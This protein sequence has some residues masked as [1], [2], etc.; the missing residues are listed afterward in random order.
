M[1]NGSAGQDRAFKD[2][3]I[4]GAG[5][6]GAAVARTARLLAGPRERVTVISDR[7][8]VV[9]RVRLH[10]VVTGRPVPHRPVDRLASRRVRVIVDPAVAIRPEA[11]EV[12]LA[13]GRCLSYDALM[14]AIGSVGSAPPSSNDGGVTWHSAA[15]TDD[16]IRLQSA[17]RSGV[18]SGP[19]TV[20]GA[21]LTGLEVATQIAGEGGVGRV[22]LI[23]AD[24]LAPW[25]TPAAREHLRDVLPRLGVDLVHAAV[26]TARPG[27]VVTDGGDLPAG[28][29]VWTG[30]FAPPPLLERS[31]LR[32]SDG[33]VRVDAHLRSVSHPE[34]FVAG[35]AA[36]RDE[37]TTRAGDGHP[38]RRACQTA[39]PTGRRPPTTRS[40][41][42]VAPR[43][44]RTACG[45]SASTW[46]SDPPTR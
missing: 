27:V 12:D 16:A 29:L 11:H 18:S 32:L 20:V 6:A 7:D 3:V 31:G 1:R 14:L 8:R 46:P 2:I 40:A 19:V 39:V 33:W 42:C 44:A 9:E 10:E 15:T 24:P 28:L 25:L 37:S 41:A 36:V 34:V 17:L 22:R 45:T 26:R 4:V 13:S 30:G 35:D 21:G 43:P 5:Y 23:T 38:L